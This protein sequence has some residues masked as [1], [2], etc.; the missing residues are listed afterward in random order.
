M[1][2]NIL[3]TLHP[4]ALCRM[5]SLQAWLHVDIRNGDRALHRESH[6]KY[7]RDSRVM[8]PIMMRAGGLKWAMLMFCADA[9]IAAIAMVIFG[10]ETKGT[11]LE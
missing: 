5:R 1:T 11:T 9:A 3:D 7:R 10:R 4:H 6:H 8:F 2:D